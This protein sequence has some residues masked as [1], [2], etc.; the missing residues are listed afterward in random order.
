LSLS[1]D[2]SRV[3]LG[4]ADFGAGFAV[5]DDAGNLDR[6]GLLADPVKDVDL[7]L[8]RIAP[9]EESAPVRQD[10]LLATLT[11]YMFPIT[12]VELHAG[13]IVGEERILTNRSGLFGWGDRSEF[14]ARVFDRV[15]RET[16]EITVPRVIRDGAA[17]AEV[18]IPEGYAAA[19][20]RVRP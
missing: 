2:R 19:I 13:W 11:T 10:A 4:D 20:I 14:T 7:E 6:V 3:A 18:R 8:A 16:T 1:H 9:S 5:A 15:G 17:Y 12:P